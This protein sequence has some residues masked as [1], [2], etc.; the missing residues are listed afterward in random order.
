M[1]TKL[2]ILVAAALALCGCERK[3]DYEF[4]SGADG[5]IMWQC[6]RKTG[7]VKLF[8]SYTS[9]FEFIHAGRD[10]VLN[11]QNGQIWRYYQNDTNSFPDEGFAPLDYGNPKA[12][13]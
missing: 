12:I 8:T 7:E 13:K 10:F 2:F 1:K 11:K 4:H 5:Q 6:N 3:P 9:S